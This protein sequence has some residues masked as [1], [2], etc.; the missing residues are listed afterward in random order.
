MKKRTILFLFLFP[1]AAGLYGVGEKT[2]SIGGAS[3]WVEVERREGVAEVTWVR[4]RPVLVLSSAAAE[5]GRT[6][7]S[8]DLALSFDEDSPDRYRDRSGR[9]RVTA[10]AGPAA[11]DRRWARAGRGAALFS[12]GGSLVVEAGAEDALFA[13]GAPAGSRSGGR[14]GSRIG[15]FT[16]E[17]WLY[18]F[19]M[20]NGEQILAWTAAGGRN[21]GPGRAGE[22]LFYQS[23]RCTAVRN[24][25]RWD[26]S[27]FFAPPGGEGRVG[28]SLGGD[29]PV[30][31]KTWSHHLVRFDAGTGLLEYLVNGRTEA[32]EYATSTGREGGEVHTPVVGGGGSFV[33]GGQFK[34]IMDEFVLW[35]GW[36]EPRLPR[37]APEGGRFETRAIDLGE[38]NSGVLRIDAA[39]GRTSVSGGEIKNDY[40]GNGVFRFADD[41][42]MQFF[43]R[44]A[45]SPYDWGGAQW[46][47]VTPGVDLPDLF[48]GRYVQIAV[49]LYPS[50]DGETSPYLEEIRLTYRPDEPPRP[51]ARLDAAAR[52]G[53]VQLDWKPSVDADTQGYLVYYGAAKGEYFGSGA[54]LGPSPI[55]AGG[56]TSLRIEGLAN[57]ALYYFA[58]AAYDRKGAGDSG[59]YHAGDCSREVSARPLRMVE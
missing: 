49:D 11:A 16:L 46:R 13:A 23:I 17:F 31:P 27:G 41:S 24:R 14:S 43:L 26:F 6:T 42:A 33:L 15:D 56:R 45:D 12:G 9:Y 44:T 48:R 1:I 47:P 55:D 40:A 39:G 2:L 21:A 57:G 58:V 18:P 51:P 50:G 25:L 4:P 35:K 36:A 5:T 30:V 3:A 8:A 22:D 29:R 32:I 7:G 20:E 59:P 19:N 53:A 52:D 38:G 54:L 10:S 34:G 28:L 37:Y